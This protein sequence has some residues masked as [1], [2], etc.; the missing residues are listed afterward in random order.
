MDERH[1]Q[2]KLNYPISFKAEALSSHFL[3]SMIRLSRPGKVVETGVAK[4]HL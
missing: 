2:V 4:G 1:K 3:Y